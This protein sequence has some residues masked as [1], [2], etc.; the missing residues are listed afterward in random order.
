C[1]RIRRSEWIAPI[2]SGYMAPC[3]ASPLTTS[4]TRSEVPSIFGGTIAVCSLSSRFAYGACR[5]ERASPPSGSELKASAT[6]SRPVGARA[7]NDSVVVIVSRV[8]LLAVAGFALVRREKFALRRSV[9]ERLG[10][11]EHVVR[12]RHL[13]D[14]ADALRAEAHRTVVVHP[15]LHAQV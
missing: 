14:L 1:A 3:S 12:V 4:A 15:H 11:T 8:L 13:R 10:Q 2:W 7:K 9:L 5:R 6:S